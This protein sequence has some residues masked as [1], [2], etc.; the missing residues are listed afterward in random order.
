MLIECLDVLNNVI[1]MYHAHVHPYSIMKFLEILLFRLQEPEV[2]QYI[3]ELFFNI[4]RLYG[5]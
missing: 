1:K 2:Q 4:T 3:D 5:L